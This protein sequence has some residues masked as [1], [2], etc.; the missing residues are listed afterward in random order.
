MQENSCYCNVVFCF[1]LFRKEIGATVETTFSIF[2][3]KLAIWW[4]CLKRFVFKQFPYWIGFTYRC[5]IEMCHHWM[6]LPCG[7]NSLFFCWRQQLVSR[8][9]TTT[10]DIKIKFHFLAIKSGRFPNKMTE[11]KMAIK[12]FRLETNIIYVLTG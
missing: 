11:Y 7:T 2:T 6:G 3:S 9:D 8:T 12:L 5:S 10:K 1:S 4:M